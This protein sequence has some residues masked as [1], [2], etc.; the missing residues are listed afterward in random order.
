M[1]KLLLQEK[2]QVLELVAV[3]V[4]LLKDHHIV[5]HVLLKV[6]QLLLVLESVQAQVKLQF[7]EM[8]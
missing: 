6:L 1:D 2:V 3:V 4:K 7:K 5:L 8:D